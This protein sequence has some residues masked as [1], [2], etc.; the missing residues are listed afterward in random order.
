MV[1]AE[2]SRIMRA[3]KSKNT[4]PERTVRSILHREGYRFRLHR[5]DLPGKPDIVFPGRRKLIFVHGCF[6]HGHNCK[7]GART[8]RTNQSYWVA[9]IQRNKDRNECQRDQLV[10]LG[11]KVCIVWECEIRDQVELIDRLTKFLN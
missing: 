5:V 2:R 1:S 7:R 9:K 6:W 4:I 8:P 10:K 3:V 11:W